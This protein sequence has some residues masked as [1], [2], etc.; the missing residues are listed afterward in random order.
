MNGAVT[1]VA[2]DAAEFSTTLLAW[3]H[4]HGR[5]LPWRT[6]RD[7]Y[8]IWLSEVM[9]QQTGVQT[10]IPYYE[11]FLRNFPNVEV[12]ASAPIDEVI[13]LWAGL[14]YY[15]RARNL[16]AAALRV[17]EDH[18][19]CFPETVPELMA[20]PG[21]GRSTAGAIR[22]IAFDRKGPILDGNVRRVLC[23]LYAL[24]DDPRSSSSEKQ[25]WQWAE[26][27]T[28]AA[29]AHDYAQAIMDFG[30]TL[31]VPRQPRCD[32]CPLTFCCTAFAQGLQR[33]LP[34]KR[35]KKTI[36]VRQEIAL[37]ACHDGHYAVRQRPLQGMLAGLWEFPS[38]QFKEP[39]CDDQLRIS[40]AEIAGQ[41]D[42]S[43]VVP[44]GRISHLYSHFR[45]DVH[46]FTLCLQALDHRQI[47]DCRWLDGPQLQTLPLHG[48]HKKIMQTLIADT[49]AN[50]ADVVR[51]ASKE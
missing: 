35:Q 4:G 47:S 20:L 39:C 42:I 49:A 41:D 16:H 21:V 45:A 12:L 17:C 32:Q 46:V 36:P 14:G 38:V 25:L 9:L 13:A 40:A 44:V 34:R 51:S 11:T 1:G 31:C 50:A 30:A 33:Q 26:T 43:S 37:L 8:R 18:D 6:S 23:R 7:P 24:Q 27:L 19:G 5:S 22:S 10:V 29:A 15:S 3:Y 48:S 28:P 2:I